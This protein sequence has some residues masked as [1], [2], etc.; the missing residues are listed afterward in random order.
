MATNSPFPMSRLMSRSTSPRE[1]FEPKPFPTFF[2]SKKAIRSGCFESAFDHAHQPVE[3]KAHEPD[4]QN[5]E[6]DARVIERVV[7][8]PEEAADTGPAGQ[9]LRRHDDQPRNAEAEPKTSEHVRQCRR[10]QHF[11]ERLGS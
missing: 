9:H 11:E 2:N 3:R 1:P 5:A 7:L 8:L 10:N 4:R 6:D